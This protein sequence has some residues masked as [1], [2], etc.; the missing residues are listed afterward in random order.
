MPADDLIWRRSWYPVAFLKDLPQDRPT[1]FTLLAEDLV[2]WHD[3]QAGCWRAF[4]DVCP[5]RL[6]PLSQGDRKSVV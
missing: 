2:L 1:A 6:V 3:R 4:A 5:H